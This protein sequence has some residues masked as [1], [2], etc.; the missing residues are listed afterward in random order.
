[1]YQ[2]Q[3]GDRQGRLVDITPGHTGS[4]GYRVQPATFLQV[5]AGLLPPQQGFSRATSAWKATPW[6]PCAPPPPLKN[7]PDLSLCRHSC[8]GL[9]ERTIMKNNWITLQDLSSKPYAES[10]ALFRQYINPGLVDLLEMGEYTS[11]EP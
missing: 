4:F 7:F 9:N 11:I 6:R 2:P 5:V 10:V 1:M 8:S 3:P